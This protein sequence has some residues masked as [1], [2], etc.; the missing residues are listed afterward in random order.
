ML[1]PRIESL[2]KKIEQSFLS[3]DSKA[4]DDGRRQLRVN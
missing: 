1:S 4:N 3:L 2:S